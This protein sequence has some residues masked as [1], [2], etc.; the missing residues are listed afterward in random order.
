MPDQTIEKTPTAGVSVNQP[1]SGTYGEKAAIAD[2]EGQLPGAGGP[3][4]TSPETGP[5]PPPPISQPGRPGG[6]P[7]NAPEGGPDVLL[8]PGGPGS[9][10]EEAGTPG[11][12]SNPESARLALLEQLAVSPEVSES[13]REWAKILLEALSA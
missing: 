12:V 3:P 1:D 6:R 2:L 5:L 9:T 7:A 4:G 8:Q 11:P 10:P 13:T